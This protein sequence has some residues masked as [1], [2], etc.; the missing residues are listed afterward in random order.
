MHTVGHSVHD[1]Q[2]AR[3]VG[4]VAASTGAASVHAADLSVILRGR[5]TTERAF[6]RLKSTQAP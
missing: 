5:T 1:E 2:F 3:S 4:F 6:R